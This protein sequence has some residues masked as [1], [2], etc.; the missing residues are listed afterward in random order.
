MNLPNTRVK[1]IKKKQKNLTGWKREEMK[2]KN[3]LKCL[4]AFRTLA[5]P[6]KKLFL[7]V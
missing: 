7:K 2:M 3:S 4:T 1:F 5:I 6:R